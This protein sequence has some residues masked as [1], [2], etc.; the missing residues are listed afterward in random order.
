MSTRNNR[1]WAVGL[2]ILFF[3]CGSSP[4]TTT[5]P[6]QTKPTPPAAGETT[7]TPPA[8][9]LPSAAEVLD[10]YVEVTGGKAAYDKLTSSVMTGKMSIPSQNISGTVEV[11]MAAP[12]KMYSKATIAGIGDQERGTDGDVAW[13]KSMMTGNRIIE[14]NEKAELMR[15]ATFNSDVLWRD[16]YPKAEVAG[17]ETIDGKPAYKVVLTT[18]EGTTQTRYYDQAS[19]LLVGT[20]Q[21]AE[22]N[23]GKIDVTTRISDYRKVGDMTVAFKNVSSMMGME[24]VM[25]IDKVE[26][27]V[28][29]PADRFA[30]PAEIQALLGGGAA[31]A[32]A[33]TPTKDS[34]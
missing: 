25:T 11:Y 5:E 22:T 2:A 29:I 16:L 31:K 8:P 1:A 34:K 14:G 27:D 32:P 24:Q 23:M 28:A 12:R 33:K 20:E 4:K 10:R 30:I 9:A 15:E 21:T 17:L 3:G 18:P 6:V 13:E 26:F 7:T 19:G